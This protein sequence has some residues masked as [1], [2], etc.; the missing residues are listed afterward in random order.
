[1]S[2]HNR[3]ACEAEARESA[4]LDA[5]AAE[6]TPILLRTTASRMQM[7]VDA[8]LERDLTEQAAV[9][10]RGAGISYLFAKDI[11]RALEA[12][13]DEIERLTNLTEQ[14]RGELIVARATTKRT[15]EMLDKAL[16]TL[17]KPGSAA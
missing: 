12:G 8:I 7:R 5:L 1:M 16:A 4:G 9:E 10:G 17:R 14:L 15:G 11:V 2:D 3:A 6:Y 13:H